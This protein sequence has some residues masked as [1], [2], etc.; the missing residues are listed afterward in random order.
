VSWCPHRAHCTEQGV[1]VELR[2]TETGAPSQTQSGSSGSWHH[3]TPLQTDGG[4]LAQRMLQQTASP[5]A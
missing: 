5:M 3:N 2:G 1:E 4:C